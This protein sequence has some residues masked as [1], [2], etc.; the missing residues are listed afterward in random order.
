MY[1]FI[2]NFSSFLM[3]TFQIVHHCIFSFRT[4]S[5]S[6]STF[7]S[8]NSLLRP[9][10][11]VFARNSKFSTDLDHWTMILKKHSNSFFFL[12][13]CVIFVRASFIL[14]FIRF[15]FFIIRQRGIRFLKVLFWWARLLKFELL[16]QRFFNCLIYSIFLNFTFF[17]IWSILFKVLDF[18]IWLHLRINR[19]TKCVNKC[20]DWFIMKP[21]IDERNISRKTERRVFDVI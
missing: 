4:K 8:L 6:S 9:S 21:K 16:S 2:R 19:N 3:L 17:H 10:F 7:F 1:L 15:V 18:K 11:D 13:N 5:F 20:L 14:L 12:F